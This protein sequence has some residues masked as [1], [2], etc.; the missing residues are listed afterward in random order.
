MFKKFLA[1]FGIIILILCCGCSKESKFGVNEFSARMKSQFEKD[2]PTS[3]FLLSDNSS[4]SNTLFFNGNGYLLSV[5]LDKSNDICGLGL[6]INDEEFI[7]NGIVLFTE[8]CSVF[9]SNDY[10]TQ[11]IIISDCNISSGKTEFADRCWVNTVGKYKYSAVCND[12]SVT[13]FCNRV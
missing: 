13:L 7:E 11:K 1:V 3:D 9:T 8:I 5:C 12:Y 4:D 2:F 10:E 6:L